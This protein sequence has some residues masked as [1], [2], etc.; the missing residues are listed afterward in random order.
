MSV[1]TS[2]LIGLG[3]PTELASMLANANSSGD[4]TVSIASG[5]SFLLNFNSETWLR[6]RQLGTNL[7]VDLGTGSEGPHDNYLYMSGGGYVD[8]VNAPGGMLELAGSGVTPTSSRGRAQLFSGS[9]VGAHIGFNLLNTTDGKILFQSGSTNKLTFEAAQNIFEYYATTT[10]EAS[11]SDGSDNLSLVLAAGGAV[12][13]S[14]GAYMQLF[15]NENATTGRVIVSSGDVAGGHINIDVPNS[16][17]SLFFQTNGVT[18]LSLVGSE[19]ILNFAGTMGNSTKDPTT[20]A[21]ADWVEI[22]IAGV[23]K[24]I[25]V[26]DAA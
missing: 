5:K 8:I 21:P 11:T 12:D 13:K 14:R 17:A 16:S 15:G 19:R 20:D 23:A 6:A 26:Y 4:Y 25:P 3:M 2:D 24:Y 22:K 9:N 10:W 7:E 18:K 1:T